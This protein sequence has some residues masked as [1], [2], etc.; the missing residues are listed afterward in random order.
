MRQFDLSILTVLLGILCRGLLARLLDLRSG[1]LLFGR[2][3]LGI[4]HAVKVHRLMLTL[5]MAYRCAASKVNLYV[6]ESL[7]LFIKVAVIGGVSM[8]GSASAAGSLYH[9]WLACCL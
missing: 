1:P 3:V 8:D 9:L 5:G 4:Y 6:L 2:N 7:V